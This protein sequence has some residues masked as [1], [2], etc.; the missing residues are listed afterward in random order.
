MSHA[1]LGRIERGLQ[2]YSQGVLE[3]IADALERGDVE[4]I[5]VRPARVGSPADIK[6]RPN[7]TATCCLTLYRPY[8]KIRA[9]SFRVHCGLVM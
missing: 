2:P 6:R 3:A 5:G 1:Q 8:V 9:C 7:Q 4:R